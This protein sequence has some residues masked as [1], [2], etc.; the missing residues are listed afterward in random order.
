MAPMLAA[1]SGPCLL[2]H[3]ARRSGAGSDHAEPSAASG[4]VPPRP[5]FVAVSVIATNRAPS[6]VD[7]PDPREM[8]AFIRRETRAR[9]AWTG[10]CTSPHAFRAATRSSALF[11]G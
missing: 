4:T 6:T 2:D 11:R 5:D 3:A 7:Q 8:P 9:R 1:T 10:A